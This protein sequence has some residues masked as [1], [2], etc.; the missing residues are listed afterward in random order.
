[1]NNISFVQCFEVVCS[2]K[3]MLINK[4][5]EEMR[6]VFLLQ[7]SDE[8]S[9]VKKLITVCLV[10]CKVV[11]P[12][13]VRSILSHWRQ[14]VKNRLAYVKLSLYCT[15]TRQF[16]YSLYNVL[17]GQVCRCCGPAVV[18]RSPAR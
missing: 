4:L 5:Y 18:T 11:V 16:G 10:C 15:A 17:K 1:M 14:Q 2:T 6:K 12:I 7:V 8:I 9:C 13:F 3:N